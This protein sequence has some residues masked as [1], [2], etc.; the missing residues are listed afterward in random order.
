[1]DQKLQ[2]DGEAQDAPPLKDLSEGRDV[3]LVIA[4]AAAIGLLGLWP[5]LAFVRDVHEFRYFHSA[6]DEDTYTLGWLNGVL[7]ST[8]LLSGICL[9]IVN[10]IGAGSLDATLIVSDF[11]FPAIAACA[12]YFAASQVTSSRSARAM[13]T[14][15]LVFAGDLFSLG[16]QVVWN[17]PALNISRF[18][19]IIG[20]IGPNLVPS[21]ETSFLAIYRTPEPQVSLSVMFVVLGLLAKF[22]SEP[23]AVKAKHRLAAIGAIS[24]LPIGYTFVTFPVALIVAGCSLIF[25]A[26]RMRANAL[27]LAIG[28]CGSLVVLAVASYW[29][30]DGSQSTSGVS[31]ALSYHSRLPI[32]TPVVLAS[33]AM[34]SLFGAW[35]VH[36]KRF[37]PRALLALACL[38]TPFVLSNQQILTGIMISAR[39]WERN[40]SSQIL[41]FGSALAI[42]VIAQGFEWRPQRTAMAAAWVSSIV[43]I[44]IAVR[45]QRLT[46]QLWLPHNETSIAMARAIETVGPKELPAMKLTIENAG[47]APLLQLRSRMKLNIP[48]TFFSV[49]IKLI[50]NM[51]PDARTAPPSQFEPA[52]FEHWRRTDITPEKAEVIIRS[53]IKVRAGTYSSY[54]FSFRDFWYPA[55]DNRAVRMV[56]LERSVDPLIERYRTYLSQVPRTNKASLLVSARPPTDQPA[57]E[58][59][60]N[61]YVGAGSA[62]TAK[63][64]VYRQHDR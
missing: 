9:S 49:G 50:P 45:G 7:R 42:A 5:H 16:S 19:Q 52:V 12:A 35:L 33:V 37:T 29:Q 15:L 3:F 56:E 41:V 38:M 54:L 13:V 2:T 6:Y 23:Q 32:I 26:H 30:G 24:L 21:Y 55:S 57:S 47:M 60:D 40:S 18:S 64:Y 46:Y 36:A 51:A 62:S 14:L 59:V 44:L 53:E 63:I 31:A 22:A 1:M 25:A 27:T 8:R 39:D 20:L 48:L 43:I 58:F 61:E 10:L 34:S 28:L 4:I 11:L 17:S